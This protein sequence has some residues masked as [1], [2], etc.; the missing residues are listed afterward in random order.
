MGQ[1]GVISE[2]GRGFNSWLKLLRTHY[3]WLLDGTITQRGKFKKKKK[4]VKNIVISS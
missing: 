3:G 1:E 2:L 4:A